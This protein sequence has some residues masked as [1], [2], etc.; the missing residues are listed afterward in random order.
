MKTSLTIAGIEVA[1]SIPHNSLETIVAGRYAP[2][3]GAVSAPV[4]SVRI[5]PADGLWGVKPS[6]IEVERGPGAA[7]QVAH[8]GFFGVIELEGEG[9]LRCVASSFALDDALRVLFALIGPSHGALMLNAAGIISGSG[10]HVFVG[11]Q[12]AGRSTVTALAGPRPV[13]TD[14]SVMVRR[15]ADDSWLAGST[16]FWTGHEIPGQPRDVRLARLW[17]LHPSAAIHSL[18]SDAGASLRLVVENMFLPTADP[19]FRRVALALAC[20]LASS[21]PFSELGLVPSPSLW[22]E[23]EASIAGA[24]TLRARL[25]PNIEEL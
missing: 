16:P 9:S 14:G 2:F 25:R 12:G 3:L 10:G 20:E 18:P 23:I 19:D 22:R 5:E 24:H 21:V 1:L 15:L 6:E 13:L 8:P 11:P 17:S 4:C 7:F